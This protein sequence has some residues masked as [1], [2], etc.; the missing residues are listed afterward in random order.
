[1]RNIVAVH[2]FADST[3]FFVHDETDI[4]MWI[5][6]ERRGSFRSKKEQKKIQN[7]NFHEK[8]K[9]SLK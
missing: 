9:K 2:S 7:V 8:M 4:L 1:M 5:W 3:F 6:W